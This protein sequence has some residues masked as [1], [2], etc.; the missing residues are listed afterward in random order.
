MANKTNI[1]SEYVKSILS[2]NPENGDFVW[3]KRLSN[4]INLGS[5]AGSKNKNNYKK[6]S[7]NNR[8]YYCHRLAF[9]FMC[10][11]MPSDEVDH[12]NGDT[13]DNRFVNLRIV[14]KNKNMANMKTKKTNRIGLKGV[15]LSNGKFISQIVK[16]K[17]HYFLGY[18]DCPAAASFAYQIASEKLNGEFSRPF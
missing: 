4:R 7:I 17:K 11:E 18:F 16:D 6:I 2:Y 10:G 12:I 15:S 8:E 1:T 14:N 3:I 9:L 13:S 5:K